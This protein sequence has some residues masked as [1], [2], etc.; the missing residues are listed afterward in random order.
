MHLNV[1]LLNMKDENSVCHCIDHGKIKVRVRLCVFNSASEIFT[2]LLHLLSPQPYWE[3]KKEYYLIVNLGC[4]LATHMSQTREM[5]RIFTHR[6]FT[7]ASDGFQLTHE[8]ERKRKR[9]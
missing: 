1:I 8:K 6:D 5:H 9:L 3:D 2:P 7:N 4:Q